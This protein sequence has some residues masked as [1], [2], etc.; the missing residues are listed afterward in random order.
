VAK[1]N[2]RLRAL[3]GALVMAIVGIV[4]A[5][6]AQ[7]QNGWNDTNREEPAAKNTPPPPPVQIAGSWNGTIQDPVQGTGAINLTF[8]ERSTKTKGILKGSWTV[9]FNNPPNAIINDVGALTGSVVGS[10]VAMTLVPRAGDALA[11]CKNMVNADNASAELIAGTFHFAGCSGNHTGPLSVQ[12]G[13]PPSTVY[14]N[15]ADD[16][17]YPVRVT[18]NA[19]QTVVWTNNGT[20]DHTVTANSAGVSK[21]KPASTEVFDSS[22]LDSG[23]TFEHTFNNPGTFGYFCQVHGC[24]MHGTI[25]V[26]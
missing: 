26:K 19:G 15:V 8:T 11:G 2:W 21:C 14:I 12:P 13:P 25:T 4:L 6:G 24:P 3:A 9:N 1:K 17:F 7:A 23:T 5:S 22:T 20:E 16:F 18:I 10:T